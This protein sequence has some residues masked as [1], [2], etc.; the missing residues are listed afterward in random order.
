MKF[1]LTSGTPEYMEKIQEKYPKEQMIL[2]HGQG[3]SILMHESD[4]KSKFAAPRQFEVLE[5]RG[6]FEQRGFVA[7]YNVPVAEESKGLFEESVITAIQTLK[8]DTSCIAYRVLKPIKHEI[9]VII[10]QW[11]G[12][13]SFDKWIDSE[14]FKAKLA[15]LLTNAASSTQTMFTSKTYITTYTAPAKEQD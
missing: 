4:K 9:Y 14:I 6:E 3:N 13:A 15:P 12:P 1:Y 7:M 8:N 5:G 11:A 10:T 2:L